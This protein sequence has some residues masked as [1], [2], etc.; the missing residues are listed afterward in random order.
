MVTAEIENVQ[1]EHPELVA[2]INIWTPQ[3]YALDGRGTHQNC[4]LIQPVTNRTSGTVY[5]GRFCDRV[6]SPNVTWG[7]AQHTCDLIMPLGCF[8]SNYQ[9]FPF[10]FFSS[11]LEALLHQ[12]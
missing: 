7:E 2:A 9:S 1:A 8:L 5:D 3:I 12:H 6:L 11:S 10:S 4:T